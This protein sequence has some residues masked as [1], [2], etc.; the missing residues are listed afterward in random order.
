[1]EPPPK[2]ASAPAVK[3][4]LSCSWLCTSTTVLTMTM[5][6]ADATARFNASKPR[7]RGVER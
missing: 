3:R 2:A 4:W 1:M 7:S 5:A 6:L